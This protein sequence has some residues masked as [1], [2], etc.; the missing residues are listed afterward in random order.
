M[1][2]TTLTYIEQELTMDGVSLA[3]IARSVGTPVYIYSLRR[4]LAQLE[5]LR[6]AFALLQPTFHY[7]LKANGNSAIIRALVGAGCGCDAVS[8]G[9]I[10]LARR[11]GCPPERIVFAGV[12]KTR[13][14]IRYALET[15]IGWLNVENAAELRRLEALASEL[16]RRPRAALRINPALHAETHRHIATGHA[17]AKFGIPLVEARMLLEHQA[18]YPHVEI[19]G[20]HIHIGSQLGRPDE[21]AAAAR[22]AME[23]TREF[24]LKHLNLGGGFP[25]AYE[26]GHAVPVEDF[27]AALVP[28]LAKQGVKVAFEPGRFL[29]AEAGVLVAEVQ[30][31]KRGGRTVVLD[32]GMNDL[33]RPALY[34][35]RHP[36]LPLRAGVAAP[37]PVQV[38]GPICES[39]D[40][41]HPAATLP[42]LAEGDLVAIGVAGAYGMSMASNYNARPRPVE[43]LVEGGAWRV[44][45]ARETFE[46][47]IRHEPKRP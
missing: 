24:K 1:P 30:Y 20:L 16:G 47:F 41:I 19:A 36:L 42:P 28:V 7:S 10:F 43:V 3:E 31:V 34:E 8:A 32:T 5:R 39:A 25:V 23:L 17:G 46:D 44:I 27:A 12:G 9:E 13:A 6:A 29:V 22:L 18:D 4:I 45:R 33:L 11:A 40:V 26:G 38:V 14:E 21:S 37:W 2:E 35:A 15:G